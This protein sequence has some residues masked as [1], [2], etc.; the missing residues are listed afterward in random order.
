[1][2]CRSSSMNS[3]PIGSALGFP[4]LKDRVA[5][6]RQS[7]NL[8]QVKAWLHQ[9]IVTQLARDRVCLQIIDTLPVP[10]C[11][12]ARHFQRRIFRTQD[13]LVGTPPTKGS[14]V[15]KDEAYFGFKGGLWITDYGLI[16]HAP[17]VQAYGHDS[18]YRDALLAGVLPAT[19]VVGDRAFIDLER[20]RKLKTTYQRHLLTPLKTNMYP[21]PARKLFVLPKAAGRLRRP[22][23]SM[24][25]GPNALKSRPSRSGMSGTCIT[26]GP[27]RILTHSICVLLKRRRHQSPLDLDGFGYFWISHASHYTSTLTPTQSDTVYR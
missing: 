12:V 27:Q 5:F 26:Y 15:A 19:K 13:V 18:T 11:K 3:S 8:W 24:P 22:R 25:S 7:A 16:F 9:H 6:T 1:M 2:A 14:W 4:V 17:L 20:K 10:I 21:T 23:P